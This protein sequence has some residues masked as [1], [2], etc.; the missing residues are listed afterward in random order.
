MPERDR[1]GAQA[2]ITQLERLVKDG[3][4]DG[5]DECAIWQEILRRVSSS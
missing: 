3:R 4:A 5:M 1:E 2:L